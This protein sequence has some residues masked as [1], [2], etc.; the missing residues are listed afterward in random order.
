L[1]YTTAN[2]NKANA[3]DT[4]FIQN[5]INHPNNSDMKKSILIFCTVIATFSLA[6]IGYMN[7]SDSATNSK[8]IKVDQEL[9]FSFGLIGC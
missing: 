6:A 7:W 3:K 5:V 9:V 1:K 4:I 2:K 8:G